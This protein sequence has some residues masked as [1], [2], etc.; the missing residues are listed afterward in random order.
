MSLCNQGPLTERHFP[1]TIVVSHSL[2]TLKK[3]KGNMG[4]GEGCLRERNTEKAEP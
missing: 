3:I 4:G 2:I 1:I